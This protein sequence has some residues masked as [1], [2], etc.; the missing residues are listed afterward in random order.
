MCLGLDWAGKLDAL[1]IMPRATRVEYSW[2]IY[3]V[4]DCGDHRQDICM[5]P[6]W[7]FWFPVWLAIIAN[8]Q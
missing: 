7:S 6:R 5:K 4:R 1:G 8:A 3:Q 2:A